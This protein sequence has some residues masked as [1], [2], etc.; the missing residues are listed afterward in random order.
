[1]TKDKLISELENDITSIK[2][3]MLTCEDAVTSFNDNGRITAISDCI[4]KIKQLNCMP[5]KRSIFISFIKE[6]DKYIGKMFE[7]GW[8]AEMAVNEIIETLKIEVE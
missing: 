7:E 8:T 2:A 5:I 6:Y 3:K 1:M 4:D